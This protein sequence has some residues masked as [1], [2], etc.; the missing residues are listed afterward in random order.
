M[1]TTENF[2]PEALGLD[3]KSDLE[4]LTILYEVKSKLLNA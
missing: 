4:I 1:H 3:E 2:Q